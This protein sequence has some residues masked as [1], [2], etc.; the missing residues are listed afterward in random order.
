MEVGQGVHE[1]CVC[2]T[3][4]VN[5][6]PKEAWEEG[7][8]APKHPGVSHP[9]TPELVLLISQDPLLPCNWAF[10]ERKRRKV[11]RS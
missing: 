6:T 4:D 2:L 8:A 9:G 1:H 5:Q 10:S 11:I 7:S 3:D